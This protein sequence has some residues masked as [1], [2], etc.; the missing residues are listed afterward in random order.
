M[1]SSGYQTVPFFDIAKK[2]SNGTLK[3][4]WLTTFLRLD[5][6][7]IENILMNYELYPKDFLCLLTV[8]KKI[9]CCII[10]I[11]RTVVERV[12]LLVPRTRRGDDHKIHN[13]N[14]NTVVPP[15]YKNWI[16]VV[17]K[18]G[19]NVLLVIARQEWFYFSISETLKSCIAYFKSIRNYAIQCFQN[20]EVYAVLL[21]TTMG[22]L[23]MRTGNETRNSNASVILSN[24][25]P[26]VLFKSDRYVVKLMMNH[27]T[28]NIFQIQNHFQ[29][30]V[31]NV[32]I[33]IQNLFQGNVNNVDN[34][35]DGMDDVMGGVQFL[36][37]SVS[38][39]VL[40][41]FNYV[42]RDDEEI[43]K[44]AVRKYKNVFRFVS[45]RL[46]KN[47]A[48]VREG[49]RN[50][51]FSLAYTPEFYNDCE[52]LGYVQEK[53]ESMVYRDQI[54]RYKAWV[55]SAMETFSSHIDILYRKIET[56][57]CLLIKSKLSLLNLT[58]DG[59]QMT[60]DNLLYMCEEN[61]TGELERLKLEY[62]NTRAWMHSVDYYEREWKRRNDGNNG[63]NSGTKLVCNDG[64]LLVVRPVISLY[65][66]LFDEESKWI[67][68]YEQYYV[69]FI[70]NGLLWDFRIFDVVSL[71]HMCLDHGGLA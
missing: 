69:N 32:D 10:S 31:D 61:L 36:S 38:S 33:E 28:L 59:E 71:L 48:F 13:Y 25:I 7:I 20:N 29:G 34:M 37:F 50:D 70:P 40:H 64:F 45:E 14:N 65:D 24:G 9:R 54:E 1:T 68:N 46:K 26:S 16:L 35:I 49:V 52:L 39:P 53:F 63:C 47:R 51:P 6:D 8:S 21:G 57:E 19:L 56:V 60:G 30:N 18:Y 67:K 66:S 42:L 41:I 5:D 62:D 17:E 2:G 12:N 43:M 23:R 27:E 4:A 58:N 44:F 55:L 3:K 15:W 22:T 11:I